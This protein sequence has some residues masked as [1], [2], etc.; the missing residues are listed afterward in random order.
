[1]ISLRFHSGLLFCLQIDGRTGGFILKKIIL[2]ASV[3]FVL[4]M[5]FF[6]TAAVY[7]A[8]SLFIDMA[9]KRGTLGDPK[10]PPAVFRSA[11]EGNGKAIKKAERP[12]FTGAKWTMQSFDGLAL[13]ATHFS[14]A[15][16]SHRWVIIVHGYGLGQEYIWDYA[17]EYLK[18]GYHAVTPDM[19]SSGSSEGMYLTMGALESRDVNDWAREIRKRDSKAEILLHGVSMGAA[20]VMLSAAQPAPGVDAVV[21]DSGYSGLKQLFAEEIDKILGIPAF[22]LLDIADLCCENRAGFSFDEASPEHVVA[23]VKIPVLFI[24][25]DEDKLV[26]YNMMQELYTACKAP[27]KQQYTAKGY[28]HAAAYQ[29]KEYFPTVFRF[30]DR[31]M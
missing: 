29:D 27:G 10:A 20:T 28:P 21:E 5:A 3:T 15:V 12:D 24:H 30:A 14:P 11:I 26:P 18:A 4:T 17:E 13:K 25:G 23:D 22:P 8:G 1:M 7:I 6:I 9:L 19:R 31:N 2:T 16:E